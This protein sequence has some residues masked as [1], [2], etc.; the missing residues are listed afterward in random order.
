M[1]FPTQEIR[2]FYIATP[3]GHYIPH[4][5]PWKVREPLNVLLGK[6]KY[7]KNC[8]KGRV[9]LFHGLTLNNAKRPFAWWRHQMETL[10][11]WLVL[12]EGNP[13]VTGGF[14]LQRPVTRSFGV[15]FDLRLNK[16]LSKQSRRLW[17]E[18]PSR[19]LLHHCNGWWW[20]AAHMFKSYIIPKVRLI[21]I[22]YQ[23]YFN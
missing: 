4:S 14:P 3:S 19:S 6:C 20:W 17:F 15:F 2:Y 7:S 9:P 16:R 10:S 8:I 18:T 13:P 1:G 12:C 21:M 11:A 22:N 23:N 5:Y